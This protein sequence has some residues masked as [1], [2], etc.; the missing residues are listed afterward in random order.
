MKSRI[1][2]QLQLCNLSRIKIVDMR[3]I[4]TITSGCK[5]IITHFS[6]CVFNNRHASNIKVLTS[7]PYEL[8]KVDAEP[9]ITIMTLTGKITLDIE[10]SDRIENAKAQIQ[11]KAGIRVNQYRLLFAGHELGD[12]H[13]LSD[14]NIRGSSLQLVMKCS[15][16]AE[17]QKRKSTFS[18]DD[19]KAAKTSVTLTDRIC[20]RRRQ[21]VEGSEKTALGSMLGR[22]SSQ[23]SKLAQEREAKRAARFP[24][25]PVKPEPASAKQRRTYDSSLRKYH[26][27]FK[28]VEEQIAKEEKKADCFR[29]ARAAR[30]KKHDAK[31]KEV[32]KL[33]VLS[34]DSKLRLFS[35]IGSKNDASD[36]VMQ[37]LP[38]AYEVVSPFFGSGAIERKLASEGVVVHGYDANKPLVILWQELLAHPLDVAVVLDELIPDFPSALSEERWQA[39]VD[40]TQPPVPGQQSTIPQG[41]GKPKKFVPGELYEGDAVPPVVTAARYFVALRC[42]KMA[43]M[44]WRPQFCPDGACRLMRRKGTFLGMV[45][46]FACPDLTVQHSDWK[47]SI[48]PGPEKYFLLDPP[49]YQPPSKQSASQ[50]LYN[51]GPEWGRRE[52][53]ALYKKLVELGTDALWVVCHSYHEVIAEIYAA[54]ADTTIVYSKGVTRLGPRPRELLIFSASAFDLVPQD[55]KPTHSDPSAADPIILTAFLK[56]GGGLKSVVKTPDPK[57]KGGL[58]SG[59][60][61][62]KKGAKKKLK[63]EKVSNICHL[64]Y[65]RNTGNDCHFLSIVAAFYRVL[66]S[67]I[68]NGAGPISAQLRSGQIASTRDFKAAAASA[69]GPF[70]GSLQQ[71]LVDSMSNLFRGLEQEGRNMAPLKTV[72]SRRATCVCGHAIVT[73]VFNEWSATYSL[74]D[75][76]AGAEKEFNPQLEVSTGELPQRMNC[77][78]CGKETTHTITR[79]SSFGSSAFFWVDRICP[80]AGKHHVKLAYPRVWGQYVLTGVIGH[81]GSTYTE[82]HYIA[83]RA[84]ADG[85]WECMDDNRVTSLGQ[86]IHPPKMIGS[87]D[88]CGLLYARFGWFGSNASTHW[89]KQSL[90]DLCKALGLDAGGTKESL[91]TRLR[92]RYAVDAESTTDPSPPSVEELKKDAKQMKQF[93]N[94]EK[95]DQLAAVKTDE[96]KKAIEEKFAALIKALDDAGD[97]VAKLQV[98]IDAGKK[99]V[100]D[101]DLKLATKAAHKR[102]GELKTIKTQA[103]KDAI[104]AIEDAL[105]TKDPVKI[106]KAMND[107]KDINPA[108]DA[109]LTAMEEAYKAF[110]ATLTEDSDKI[111]EIERVAKLE[112]DSTEAK[113]LAEYKAMKADF[114]AKNAGKE[115]TN[116]EA[117]RAYTAKSKPYKTLQAEVTK[118]NDAFNTNMDTAYKTEFTAEIDALKRGW[119]TIAEAQKLA[120]HAI[121]ESLKEGK[122]TENVLQ[123]DGSTADVPATADEAVRK[124][125][126]VATYKAIAAKIVL[127]EKTK[128]ASDSFGEDM[129]TTY[130]ADLAATEI[131]A[132]KA[133]WALATFTL[134]NKVAQFALIKSL[135]EGKATENVPQPDGSTADVPATADEA[136]RKA[137]VVATYKAIAKVLEV[138]TTFKT[139]VDTIYQAELQAEK[140]TLVAYWGTLNNQVKIQ[141][142]T[143]AASLKAGTQTDDVPQ[144]DGTE[145]QV[146]ATADATVQKTNVVN[147]YKVT[148]IVAVDAW[149]TQVIDNLQPPIVA[150]DRAVEMYRWALAATDKFAEWAAAKD[151]NLA[152]DGANPSPMR[153]YFQPKWNQFVTDAGNLF[154]GK[155]ANMLENAQAHLTEQ[156]DINQANAAAPAPTTKTPSPASTTTNG[157]CILHKDFQVENQ[158]PGQCTLTFATADLR[159]III[160]ICPTLTIDKHVVSIQKA[161]DDLSVNCTWVEK[162]RILEDN[163]FCTAIN[164]LLERPVYKTGTLAISACEKHEAALRES[165]ESLASTQL[166][167]QNLTHELT[168]TKQNLA[169]VTQE[170]RLLN[171]EISQ[172]K[173]ELLQYKGMIDLTPQLQS[174]A[175][176]DQHDGY[177]ADDG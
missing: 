18:T 97:D 34:T 64:P 37:Y 111:L 136:V 70:G 134:Q 6:R 177:V 96:D 24:S 123:A 43:I 131:A 165:A 85:A 30:Q 163:C 14:Y 66:P 77:S 141:C 91:A 173:M 46:D 56:A 10:A 170:K 161:D 135:T 28:K 19:A 132:L 42:A 142:F 40:S 133:E 54:H 102:I 125:N 153:A 63:N 73:D 49:Y 115:F 5:T 169:K 50:A 82:G 38:R 79:V 67:V 1:A 112:G 4:F 12:C 58:K 113:K 128:E 121:I 110:E 83:L 107:A 129:D 104:K 137:N 36:L 31:A 168:T 162:D 53:E 174:T 16:G 157:G 154:T 155:G 2:K 23:L 117:V 171:D 13:S 105:K 59:D 74:V 159:A 95:D 41:W 130:T 144:I 17:E 148:A 90:V 172:L 175:A 48:I 160:A 88:V 146:A 149:H 22:A 65:N 9:K 86:T 27:N 164:E 140:D 57:A 78:R 87:F 119:G 55:L 150:N 72:V 47:D 127:D 52:H 81:R 80:E 51:T 109:D 7:S 98:A 176:S 126:V 25:P 15:G 32:A 116:D 3:H 145:A 8:S 99:A 120:Q 151:K 118:A 44:G 143:M 35:W 29:M 33:G 84:R 11:H 61:D 69:W 138:N 89:H 152:L 71:D 139:D 100:P 60:A 156:L 92:D 122:K 167:V 45:A 147:F 124:A 93:L 39:Y 101:A 166:Q 20:A 158:K 108:P 103:A 94:Q 68:Q 114:L 26:Q 76:G 21:L 75:D 62:A 106:N